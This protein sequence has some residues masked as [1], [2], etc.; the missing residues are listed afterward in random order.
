MARPLRI[1][2]EGD[3]YRVTAYGNEQKNIFF[4]KSDYKKLLNIGNMQSGDLFGGL[5]YSAVSKVNQRFAEKLIYPMS[6]L[7]HFLFLNL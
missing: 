7:T 1:E 2:H 5:S 6:R 4:N 3:V